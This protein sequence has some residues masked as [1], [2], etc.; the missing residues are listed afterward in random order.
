MICGGGAKAAEAELVGARGCFFEDDEA[1][2]DVLE[3]VARGDKVSDAILNQEGEDQNSLLAADGMVVD[4]G[5]VLV[6]G[7]DGDGFSSSKW[8]EDEM[9]KYTRVLCS[10]TV[11]MGEVH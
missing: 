11:T 4:D 1:G 5:L 10:L 8:K 6:R 3:A 9:K 7:L 2:G